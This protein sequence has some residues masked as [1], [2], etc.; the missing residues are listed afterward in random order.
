VID[1]SELLSRASRA[2]RRRTKA[3]KTLAGTRLRHHAPLTT[4][5]EAALAQD[6]AAERGFDLPRKERSKRRHELGE[7]AP[8]IHWTPPQLRSPG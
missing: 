6:Y 8:A 2:S 1:M 3:L 5:D 7:G 4:E